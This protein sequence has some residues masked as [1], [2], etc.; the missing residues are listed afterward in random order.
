[1]GYYND[2]DDTNPMT[3]RNPIHEIIDDHTRYPLQILHG[4][5]NKVEPM[6]PK[7]RTKLL[8]DVVIIFSQMVLSKSNYSLTCVFLLVLKQLLKRS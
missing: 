4:N 1:M 7:I 6:A 2:S 3:I 5:M 8:M